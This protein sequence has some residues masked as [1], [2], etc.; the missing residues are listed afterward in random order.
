MDAGVTRE[1]VSAEIA[2]IPPDRAK[3]L[4]RAGLGN[5]AP[6][7]RRPTACEAI[8]AVM[9]CLR[10]ND[11]L[12]AHEIIASIGVA[13]MRVGGRNLKSYK[14]PIPGKWTELC[15]LVYGWETFDTIQR[16]EHRILVA[17]G[18]EYGTTQPEW[19][20]AAVRAVSYDRPDG[21]AVSTESTI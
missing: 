5:A 19:L 2:C 12:W 18:N 20:K 6:G 4:V 17:L 9:E 14:T 7:M 11:R 15:G 21:A 16:K 13:Q 1:Q 10:L 8:F 3:D